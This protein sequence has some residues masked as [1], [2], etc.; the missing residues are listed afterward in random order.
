[1]EVVL[2]DESMDNW[3]KSHGDW[4]DDDGSSH[5][6]VEEMTYENDAD[7]EPSGKR[8]KKSRK[9]WVIVGLVCLNVMVLVAFIVAVVGYQKSN[10]AVQSYGEFSQTSASNDILGSG[11]V[12]TQDIQ[13]PKMEFFLEISEPVSTLSDGEAA[14]LASAIVEGYNAA[15]LGCNGDA[16]NRFMYECSLIHQALTEY[17]SSDGPVHTLD[18]LFDCKIS[19]NG[20]TAD[21]AF[22][23][24]FPVSSE[25]RHLDGSTLSAASI[26]AEIGSRMTGKADF[27]SIIGVSITTD[28]TN[29]KSM[30]SAEWA[31]EVTDGVSTDRAT[32]WVLWRD[33]SVER[34][35]TYDLLF[36]FFHRASLVAATMITQTYRIVTKSMFQVSLSPMKNS[37]IA[38]VTGRREAI[39]VT[40]ARRVAITA[41]MARRV[42]T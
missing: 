11:C 4:E 33:H 32:A 34:C 41:T 40:M 16:Y 22:A 38:M 24:E 15:S 1:M 7:G 17:Y 10:E 27:D 39:T 14:S 30:T 2:K 3:R 35:L 29:V 13:E 20:C 23:D 5:L 28:A 21:N 26:M 18:A 25:R 31:P 42:A 37:P 19:C 9:T 36:V 6:H 8:G 12:I